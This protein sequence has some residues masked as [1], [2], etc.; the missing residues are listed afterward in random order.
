MS[1]HEAMTAYIR[2]M[3]LAA[4]RYDIKQSNMRNG[5]SK[6]NETKTVSIALKAQEIRTSVQYYTMQS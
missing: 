4:G 6:K 1:A 5:Q 2:M 3:D